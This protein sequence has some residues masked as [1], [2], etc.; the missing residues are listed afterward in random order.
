MIPAL[1]VT[2]ISYIIGTSITM[3][4]FDVIAQLKN[5]PYIHVI[6]NPKVYKFKAKD[7]INNTFHYLTI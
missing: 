5:L 3:S 7:I 1:I 2:L 6:R 4:I